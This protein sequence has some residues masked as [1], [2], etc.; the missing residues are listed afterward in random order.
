V[1]LVSADLSEILA[2]ADRVVVLYAGALRG[3][4]PIADATPE[5]VGRLMTGAEDAA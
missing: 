3:P 4:L 1:L 2:L 5:R